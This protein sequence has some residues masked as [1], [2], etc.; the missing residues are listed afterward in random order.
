MYFEHVLCPSHPSQASDLFPFIFEI[1]SFIFLLSPSSLIV[2]VSHLV[3]GLWPALVCS[4]FAKG[5]ILGI[6]LL[7]FELLAN[8]I[9]EIP[10]HCR[11]LIILLVT[12]QNLSVR[13]YC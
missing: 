3:L 11:L 6:N 9:T 12:L 13:P 10:K 2:C 5:Y 4:Q 8:G 1:S 7:L